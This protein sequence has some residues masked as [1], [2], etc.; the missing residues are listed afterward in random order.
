METLLT[1]SVLLSIFHALIPSHWL[2]V[3]AIGRQEGWSTRQMLWVTFLA[4]MAHV[5]S[6]VLLGGILAKVGESLAVQTETFTHW[7]APVIL[8]ALGI[9]YVWRH[10]YHHHFHL[11]THHMR[12]GMVASLAAAM[13]FS[14][15]LE[16][17]GY[18]LAAGRYG[19]AFT[20]L[21]AGVYGT[22]T[23]LGM[24]FW[25]WL[26]LNGLHRLNWHKWEH[27]AGLV[28]GFT[29]LASGILLYFFD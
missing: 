8:V 26:V 22:V 6:T 3:L 5:L 2:P 14:P 28:T 23:I 20:G 25:V 4:G 7:L 12:W 18:F 27:N 17:E 10:Y 9:Y 15:C 16:I 29:L 1:G 11:H 24:L 19:W 21:L 13:F